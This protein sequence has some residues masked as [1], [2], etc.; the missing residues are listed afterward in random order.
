LHYFS[1]CLQIP[2]SYLVINLQINFKFDFDPLIFHEGMALGLR[3]KLGIVI[4][5]QCFPLLTDNYLIFC[6]LL[7]LTKLQIKF[8]L[9]FD[10]LIFHNVMTIR[11]RKI[12]S[13][14][15]LRFCNPPTGSVKNQNLAL[16]CSDN[17]RLNYIIT[18]GL[19]IACNFQLV[20]PEYH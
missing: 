19:S 2:I 10:P 3:T 16:L 15:F 14:S 18:M 6:T 4:S 9:D 5:P 8:K 11:L 13:V 7:C 12:L 20:W 1:L 17:F